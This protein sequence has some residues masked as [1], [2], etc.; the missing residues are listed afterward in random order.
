MPNLQDIQDKIFFETKSILDSLSRIDSKEELLAKQDLLKEAADRI[1]FL[2]IFEK[3]EESFEQLLIKERNIA[4]SSSNPANY[5][6]HLQ[7]EISEHDFED[8]I[9]EEEVLFTNELNNMYADKEE[10]IV[11]DEE[12]APVES[13]TEENYVQGE[14]IFEAATIESTTIQELES[15]NEHEEVDHAE[16]IAQKEKDLEEMEDR[17]RKIVEFNK[18]E[19]EIKLPQEAETE[20]GEPLELHRDTALQQAEK[21]FKLASIKGLKVVQQLFDD[22]PLEH[23]EV[24]AEKPVD[25]GSLLKTNIQTDFMEAERKKPEFRLD[26]NDKVAFT[27][28]LFNGNE[29]ELKGAIDRLNSFGTLDEA[30]H[31]LSEIYHER[32]WSKSDEYAQRLWNLVENKFM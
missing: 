9:I 15:T 12:I 23:D 13:L 11:I 32:D 8:D 4:Q 5:E 30:K 20:K 24:V 29:Q 17:R 18:R 2:R 7:D 6:T 14:P 16:R 3:N 28:G 21:K 31:Y 25:S 27:K 26:L 22:D 19:E 1:A 10:E